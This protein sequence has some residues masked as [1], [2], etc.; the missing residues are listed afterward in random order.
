MNRLEKDR[1]SAADVFA[2]IVIVLILVTAGLGIM[3][4]QISSKSPHT[5][6]STVVIDEDDIVEFEYVG[7]FENTRKVFE[8]SMYDVAIDNETYTKALSFRWPETDVFEPINVTIGDGI[9]PLDFVNF[10]GMI[11]DGN[12]LLDEMI[13]MREGESRHIPLKSFEAFGDPDPSKIVTLS[14]METLDQVE[15]LTSI[16]FLQRM[17]EVEIIVNATYHDPAWGWDVRIIKEEHVGDI[18]ELTIRN[19]PTEGQRVTPYETFESEVVSIDS[20]ANEG[21]GEI[22][23]RH[24]ISAEDANNLMAKSPS[25][26]WFILVGLDEDAGTFVADFN[27]EKAGKSLIYEVTVVKIV[28][29]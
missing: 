16:E 7:R 4:Y 3:L 24:L 12:I 29:R 23:L 5:T 21:K 6:P 10:T 13:G 11:N 26:G 1:A 9:S 14:L 17:G 25:E 15:V 27:S 8:T 2:V 20:A 19:S 22:V 18:A 28:K